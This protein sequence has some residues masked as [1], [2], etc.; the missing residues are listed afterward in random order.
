VTASADPICCFDHKHGAVRGL[1]PSRRRDACGAC[2]DHDDLGI[3]RQR[4]GP[5][6][7]YAHSCSTASGRR[8]ESAA[9]HSHGMVSKT[10]MQE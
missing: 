7:A 9:C 2:A 8:Q 1:N 4:R 6:A 3:A 5:R 10:Q